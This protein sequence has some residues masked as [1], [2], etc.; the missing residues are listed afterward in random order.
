MNVPRSARRRWVIAGV[1]VALYSVLLSVIWSI[2]TF[3]AAK[4][5]ENQLDY[6]ILDFR[7]T[8][9]GAIDTMLGYVAL[10]AVRHFGK[11]EAHTLEEMSAVARQLDMDEINLV[12]RT[13]RIIASN[14]PACINVDM[15][16]LPETRPFLELTN[17][18]TLTVSQPFRK[19]AHDTMRRKYLGMAFPGGDGYVQIG[20]DES[21]LN[22]MLPN[23]LR[24]IFDEWLLGRTGFFLCADATTDKLISNPSRHRDEAN[25]LSEAGFDEKSAQPFEIRDNVSTG[26]TF[27]QRLFGEDCYCRNYL[28]GGHRFIPALPEREYY[29]TRTAYISVFGIIL[30]VVLLTFA[31][32]IDRIFEDSDCLKAF[33]AAE[34]ERR[35]KDFL[36]AKTIQNSALPAAPPNSSSF[37]ISATMTAAKDVGGDFYDYFMLDATHCAFLV[38]DV[39]G[40]GVTAALYM[41]TVKTLIKDTLIDFHDPA[42]ALT[43][44][45]ADLYRNN[46]ANMFLTAWVGVLDMETGVVAFANAGHNP[47][48]ILPDVRFISAK[49]GPALAFMDDVEYK[50]RH[51]KLRPG[52]TLFLYTDGVTEALDAK[53][54]FFGEERLSNAL[55]A[56]INASSGA[57]LPTES[58]LNVALASVAAF[59][60][61]VP[62]ADDITALVVRYI[63]PPR[64]YSRSFPPTADGIAS[65]SEY[66]D[67]ILE[68]AESREILSAPLHVILDEI[69]SNIV[70]HSGASGFVV[71]VDFVENPNGVKLVFI[72]DGRPFDPLAH[73]DPDITLSVQDRPIGGLGILMVKK[74]ATNVSYNRT[75][76]RNFLTVLKTFG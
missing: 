39:S 14:D 75:H 2:G 31:L 57:V 21:R 33:Y 22:V 52:D 27:Q 55:K 13:G 41:M 59:A 67:K 4:K 10:T 6:A 16:L 23:I 73:V 36:L 62:Q 29:D 63:A 20:L 7:S 64:L 24:Y 40:K 49:S 45:N 69:C 71:D 43:K 30:F 37:S 35:A 25:T 56:C 17:G 50:L 9:G 34:E 47:P 70:K 74:M 19:H 72:D 66:L 68:Q 46:P 48:V 26:T 44:I 51:L 12:D 61:G 32:F 3:E 1:A 53:N 38:A 60:E 5:T 18:V 58:V 54:E 11:V 42:L 28:F 76:N 65:A 8:I 15:A